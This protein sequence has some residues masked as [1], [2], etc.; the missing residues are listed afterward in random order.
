MLLVACCDG[1]SLANVILPISYR[2]KVEKDEEY[3]KAVCS[4]GTVVTDAIMKNNAIDIY[5]QYFSDLPTDHSAQVPEAKVLA[6][7]RDPAA[8]P[9]STNCVSF[10]TDG[11]K[12]LVTAY[13]ILD[14][15]QQPANMSLSSYIWDVSNPNEPDTELKPES[16]LVCSKFNLKD[17]NVVGAGQ[18]NGQFVYFDVRKGSLAVEATPIE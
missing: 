16:Q 14:F 12:K 1:T 6:V 3:I 5:E 17:P 7:L 8:I 11:A 9:R 4:L 18:Y 13:S 15:Q 10:Q 2:K